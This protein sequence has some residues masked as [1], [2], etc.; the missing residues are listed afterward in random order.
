MKSE[1]AEALS[2][3]K[4]DPKIVEV[5]FALK[6][7]EEQYA[8]IQFRA[9]DLN[10][11]SVEDYANW[12]AKSSLISEAD[13]NDHFFDRQE[14]QKATAAKLKELP[15]KVLSCLFDILEGQR[16]MHVVNSLVHSGKMTRDI[17]E[18]LQQTLLDR[19]CNL[20]EYVS[21]LLWK[22]A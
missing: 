10:A 21:E 11:P 4:G 12:R 14:E 8:R 9:E 17:E 5:S 13:H 22:E 3:T 1:Q 7:S 19:E 20:W 15:Y 6:L 18:H 16:G 2:S